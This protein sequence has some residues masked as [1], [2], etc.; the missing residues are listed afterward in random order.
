MTVLKGSVHHYAYNPTDAND[1]AQ[2]L[3]SG[4]L[5]VWTI[6]SGDA[7]VAP[8]A[9]GLSAAVTFG[10]TDGDVV[11]AADYT[12]PDGDKIPTATI[13]ETV[14]D[15]EDTKATITKID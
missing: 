7:T 2:P 10:S 5:P 12:Y 1:V 13:T 8:A 6:Q 9:D 4:V 11:I 15:A 14:I 3:A